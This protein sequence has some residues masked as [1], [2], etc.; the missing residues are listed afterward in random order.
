MT[1]GLH[2]VR[3]LLRDPRTKDEVAFYVHLRAK[4]NVDYESLIKDPSSLPLS[5]PLQVEH[6]LR[7]LIKQ[8]LPKI[9]KNKDIKN[10]FDVKADHQKVPLIKDL[11][12]MKPFNPKLANKLFSLSNFGLQEKYISKFSGARSIQKATVDHYNSEA[13]VLQSVRDME[14]VNSSYISCKRKETKALELLKPQEDICLTQLAQDLRDSMWGL[15]L[16]GIT[17]PAQQ[18]QTGLYRWED[19][20]KVWAPHAVLLMVDDS[21]NQGC[22]YTRGK[23]TPYYGSAT[24][25]RVRRAPLQVLEVGNIVSSIKQLMEIR[26]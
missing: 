8:H 10:L 6:K 26:G 13:D 2:W 9:I 12:K 23:H 24:K 20:P 16:E 18:E 21:V 19:V 15:N 3:T 22:G 7:D 17:M 11:S 5:T 1:S 4:R 14:T 25:M